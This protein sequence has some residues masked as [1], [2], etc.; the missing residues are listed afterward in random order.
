MP[1]QQPKK[2]EDATID[3][4]ADIASI[5]RR[6]LFDPGLTKLVTAAC[7]WYQQHPQM[8]SEL[9]RI[10]RAGRV[11]A[12]A[13]G[14]ASPLARKRLDGAF[15]DGE[16]ALGATLDAIAP[17]SPRAR[18]ARW[19]AKFVI[20]LC[21]L[22]DKAGGKLTL[23]DGTT[24]SKVRSSSC[25]TSLSPIFLAASFLR[26]STPFAASRRAPPASPRTLGSSSSPQPAVVRI[27]A[28]IHARASHSPVPRAS[29]CLPPPRMLMTT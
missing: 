27:A 13:I 28:H 9:A 15:P 6:D 11:F 18:H 21:V 4:C 8:V 20:L 2:L 22:V 26:A 7:R 25:L 16:T 5:Q 23:S 19:N 17:A 3:R 24:S 1:P 14:K 12:R 29:K 10:V